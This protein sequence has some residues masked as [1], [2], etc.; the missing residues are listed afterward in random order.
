MQ[1]TPTEVTEL[2]KRYSLMVGY[3]DSAD[4]A[5]RDEA[6]DILACAPQAVPSSALTPFLSDQYPRGVRTVALARSLDVYETGEE[7][8]A[9][10]PADLASQ[11]RMKPLWS[12]VF[13]DLT[14]QSDPPPHFFA[15]ATRLDSNHGME[16][17]P[18]EAFPTIMR[19]CLGLL[20]Q[21]GEEYATLIILHGFPD[22]LVAPELAAW[23]PTAGDRNARLLAVREYMTTA[24]EYNRRPLFQAFLELAARDKDAEIANLAKE[25]LAPRK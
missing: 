25:A 1:P 8:M 16:A 4:P 10:R 9:R 20:S 13:A 12:K 2:L 14:R 7:L 5:L 6:V 19:W 3:L 24:G 23:Y 22:S 21:G 15:L 11:E 17:I 18:A